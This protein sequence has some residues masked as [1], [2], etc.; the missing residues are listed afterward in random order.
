MASSSSTEDEENTTEYMN[1]SKNKL[2]FMHITSV[3][4]EEVHYFTTTRWNTY[5]TSLQTWLGLDGESR[6][7]AE[8]FK[9]CVDVEFD[10]IPEDAGFHHTCYRRFTDKKSMAKVERRLARERQEATEDH[11][12]IPSTSGGTSPTKK[13]RSRSGLPIAGSGPVLPA[14]GIICQKKEKFV[15]RAGKRQRDTLSKA[16]TLTAGQLQKAA[17]LKED[18]SILL[19][20]QDKDCVALEVQ[21]HKGCYNQYTR[22]LMRP[23]KPEKE[24]NEPTFDVSD[25]IFCERII[26]QRLLVNQEVLRMGQLRKAFIEL[27]KANEGLDACDC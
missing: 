26:R 24:Q 2:C 14:L 19:H 10:N 7:V 4:H 18:Q 22:F 8:N 12:A 1:K 3:K 27:V 25:K 15:N 5:R 6:D 17:E 21:D 16:E 20:I 13:L 23:E 11:E 9:H